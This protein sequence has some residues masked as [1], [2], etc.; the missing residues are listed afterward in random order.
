MAL[1]THFQLVGPI[2][3]EFTDED[4]APLNMTINAYDHYI[5][6]FQL[7]KGNSDNFSKVRC[8]CL[9]IKVSQ[10]TL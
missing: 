5:Q 2:S 1:K 9:F 8:I 6:G 3:L 10:F 4:F 7:E